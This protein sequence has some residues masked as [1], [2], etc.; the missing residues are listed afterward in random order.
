LPSSVYYEQLER[1]KWTASYSEETVFGQTITYL[2]DLHYDSTVNMVKVELR[3]YRKQ[4]SPFY[5]TDPL[6]AIHDYKIGVSF[7]INEALG[8]C[9]ITPISNTSLG[10]DTAYAASLLAANNSYVI[11]I[12]SPE[13]LL[14][15]DTPY[16]Y[17]GKD[18]VYGVTVDRYVSDRSA[19]FKTPLF[20]EYT[21]ASDE[22]DF[23]FGKAKNSPLTL[24]LNSPQVTLLEST[25]PSYS[26]YSYS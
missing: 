9:T 14:Q 2:K 11:R 19:L 23:D 12:K 10:S 22:F 4:D 17:T 16:V 20:A 26:T 7:T 15:L 8:N 25:N 21:F 5:V 6:L 24:V 18:D 3:D 1:P 13:A